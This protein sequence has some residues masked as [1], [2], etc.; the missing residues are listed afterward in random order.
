M[1]NMSRINRITAVNVVGDTQVELQFEDGFFGRVDLGPALWGPVFVP[2]K[3]PAYFRQVRL[4]DD[5]IRWPNEADFCPDV[6]R[7]WCEAG[8]V[9]SPQ[10]TDEYFAARAATPAS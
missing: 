2:L 4:E 10:E 6:L 3:D 1:L 5:T 7:F 9:Q 8:G